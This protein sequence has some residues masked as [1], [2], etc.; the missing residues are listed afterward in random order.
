MVTST[1]RDR[2]GGPCS[3]RSAHCRIPPASP[4]QPP[5][6]E[7]PLP[8]SPQPLRS[9]PP[10][11]PPKPPLPPSPQRLRSPPPP[12]PPKPPLPRSP[13]PPRS[14]PLPPPPRRPRLSPPPPPGPPL[15]SK[16]LAQ[17]TCAC[18]RVC[19]CDCCCC[20]CCLVSKLP[21][22][23]PSPPLTNQPPV[24]PASHVPPCSVPAAAASW[25]PANA[26][27]PRVAATRLAAAAPVS[28]EVGAGGRGWRA[29]RAERAGRLDEV[30]SMPSCFYL[31]TITS[32]FGEMSA[33]TE[34]AAWELT[35]CRCRC[36][37]QPGDVCVAAPCSARWAGLGLLC[38]AAT[39][40]SALCPSQLQP[41]TC[42]C[43]QTSDVSLGFTCHLCPAHPPPRSL[44]LLRCQLHRWPLLGQAAA[45][46]PVSTPVAALAARPSPGK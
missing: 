6:P 39:S 35:G 19:V 12:P 34:E 21:P 16:Y 20:C 36:R 28:G 43:P 42:L 33:C 41:P 40:S 22:P 25:A 23:P 13:Q 24:L 27:A 1:T 8:S 45:A 17:C 46:A 10:P 29:C 44:H 7:P 14:P 37:Y 26:S 4:L 18:I 11:P 5:P 32:V 38:T 3:W 30:S 2:S 15:V 9:P 31:I